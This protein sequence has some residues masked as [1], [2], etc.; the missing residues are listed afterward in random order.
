M[1]PRASGGAGPAAKASAE[2]ANGQASGGDQPWIK[3]VVCRELIYRPDFDRL[4]RCCPQCN[5]HQRLR[6]R[7]RIEFTADEGTFRELEANLISVDPLGF[8]GYGEKLESTR[9]RS[10]MNEAVIIGEAR[11]S[12]FPIILGALDFHFQAGTM[13]AAVGEKVCRA[14][15]HAIERRRPVIFFVASGGARVNEGLHSLMQMAKTSA[16]V[17]RMQAAALPYLV[18]LTDPSMA[19]VLA[20]FASLGDVTL[21]EP[22]ALIGFTGPRV[23]EQQ[24]RIKLPEGHQTA[25]FQVEHGMVDM[26]VDRV[27]LRST[28]TTLLRALLGPDAGEG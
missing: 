27:R 17:A 8:P 9:Q 23:I 14:F 13:T 12:G 10:G 11:L 15:E 26:I 22:K 18:V 4:L 3:C 5:H 19:G 1:P 21:A 28:L 16:A 24:L 6:A 2:A 7:E 25:E 20:S